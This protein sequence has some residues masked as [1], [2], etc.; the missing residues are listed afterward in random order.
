MLDNEGGNAHS[1]TA[2]AI[3]Q[4]SYEAVQAVSRRP[5]DGW[6]FRAVE[7]AGAVHMLGKLRLAEQRPR[8]SGHD[9]AGEPHMS[10][11]TQE[12]WSRRRL[13]PLADELASA[14]AD[15]V[16]ASDGAPST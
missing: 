7:P 9:R 12:M 1:G 3:S 8:R 2:W 4:S 16:A 6:Q 10:A 13:Y 5:D 11:A 15:D 14:G